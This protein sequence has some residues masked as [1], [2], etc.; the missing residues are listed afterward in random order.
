MGIFSRENKED[1]L[2]T[3]FDWAA[4]SQ[5]CLSYEEVAKCIPDN[6]SLD[7]DC[8]LATCDHCGDEFGVDRGLR[9]LVN[10]LQNN[11]SGYFIEVMVVQ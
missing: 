10:H 3:N 8:K 2:F 9:F 5:G 7:E 11:H 4:F 1:S 6:F